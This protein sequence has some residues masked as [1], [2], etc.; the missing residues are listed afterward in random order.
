V[1]SLVFGAAGLLAPGYLKTAHR[2]WMA[3]GGTLGWVNSRV[4]MSLVYYGMV[5]P[6]G[7]IMRIVGYDPMHR[8]F[9]P[10]ND[11]Y[12]VIRQTRSAAHMSRQF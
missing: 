10:S 8:N 11:T 9:E 2:I 4:I 7:G 6:I 12:R 3:I 5:T 1:I